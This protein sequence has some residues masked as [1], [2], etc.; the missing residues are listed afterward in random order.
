[1]QVRENSDKKIMKINERF[2]I[3]LSFQSEFEIAD[4]KLWFYMYL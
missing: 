3:I 1:M 4:D 2:S